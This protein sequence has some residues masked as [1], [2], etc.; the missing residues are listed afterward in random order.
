[1]S[2]GESV[3]NVKYVIFLLLTLSQYF[4]VLI[5][6]GYHIFRA[7]MKQIEARKFELCVLHQT[8][9]RAQSKV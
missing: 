1:M 6:S 5:Y 8:G 3:L 4:F 2:P 7:F 9:S